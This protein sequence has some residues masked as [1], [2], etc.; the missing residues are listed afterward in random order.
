MT[1]KTLT[2]TQFVATCHKLEALTQG[3][4]PDLVL[5]I[6]TGGDYV[7]AVIHPT[8][9]HVSIKLQRPTT[10]RKQGKMMNIV[11]HLPRF[12]K[13][14]LRI[15]ESLYLSSPLNPSRPRNPSQ[16][17]PDSPSSPG[18][19]A[20]LPYPKSE[21]A[22]LLSDDVKAAVTSAHR[23]LIVDDAVDSGQTL[24]KIVT[25]IRT[26]SPHAIIATAVITVTTK[27]PL[28]TPDYTLYNNRTLIRFPWS[29]DN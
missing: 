20:S 22:S 8:V 9:P 10:K 17:S 28:I 16:P 2:Q 5:T 29:A 6:A 3:F 12:L 21:L 26:H 4:H 24:H 14:W 1:V 15:A 25:A 18:A 23:I 11:R 27:N 7:G 13:N 19:L